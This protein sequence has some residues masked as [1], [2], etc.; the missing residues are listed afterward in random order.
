[1]IDVHHKTA[2]VVAVASAGNTAYSVG[3][4]DQ[5]WEVSLSQKGFT[6]VVLVIY[7]LHDSEKADSGAFKV[8]RQ[9][10]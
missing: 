3:F 5:L 4:D 7:A 9:R 1:M 6:Y 2:M 8:R 10:P